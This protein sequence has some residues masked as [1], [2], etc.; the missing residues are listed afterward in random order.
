MP[1]KPAIINAAAPIIGGIIIPPVEAAAS[2]APAK[3]G[4]RPMLFIRGIVKVPV[5]A[6]LATALPLSEPVR[7]E[8]ITATCAG[9]PRRRPAI[10]RA[11]SLNSAVAP[12]TLKNEPNRIKTIIAVDAVDSVIPKTP[13]PVI[14]RRNNRRSIENPACPKIPIKYC[15][16]N[17]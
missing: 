9:P 10:A 7:A 16:N 11:R 13:S 17:A 12:L 4:D 14:N 3:R 6:T 1:R 2:T 15:P 5:V 8:E